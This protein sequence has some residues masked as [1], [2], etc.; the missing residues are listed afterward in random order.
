MNEEFQVICDGM[1]DEIIELRSDLAA[2]RRAHKR[3]KGQVADAT[4]S[5]SEA[6]GVTLI[7]LTDGFNG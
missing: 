5:L 4:K 7:D 1:R 6:I 3:L 2:E